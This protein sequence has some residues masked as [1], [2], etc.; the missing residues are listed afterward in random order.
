LV[1]IRLLFGR[2][3]FFILVKCPLS[4]Q[5]IT[6]W[7]SEVVI[8]HVN[9]LRRIV[10]YAVGVIDM[11]ILRCRSGIILSHFAIGFNRT[12]FDLFGHRLD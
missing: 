5:K 3:L 11:W 4:S 8:L 1:E 9:V 2:R 10:M 12:L 7:Q 6:I